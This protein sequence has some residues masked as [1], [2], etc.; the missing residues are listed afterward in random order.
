MTHA[1]EARPPDAVV[2]TGTSLRRSSSEVG[3]V[4]LTDC[5]SWEES[6]RRPK[7][8]RLTRSALAGPSAAPTPSAIVNQ[9]CWAV[10]HG[11]WDTRDSGGPSG[12]AGT[13]AEAPGAP[14]TNVPRRASVATT[15]VQRAVMAQRI[16]TGRG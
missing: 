11:V 3:G 10:T 15:S 6:S 16:G 1:D 5:C 12:R 2:L 7:K 13:D 8:V 14:A 4:P 9:G